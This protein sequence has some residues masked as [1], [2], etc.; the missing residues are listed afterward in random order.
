[1]SSNRKFTISCQYFSGFTKNIDI[2]DYNSI[3]EIVTSI[4]SSLETILF[5]NNLESLLIKFK[6][7][8]FHVHDY[9]FFDVLTNTDSNRVFYICSHC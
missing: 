8:K 5:E 3:E 4:V 2:E 6:S 7:L 1:M 9:N